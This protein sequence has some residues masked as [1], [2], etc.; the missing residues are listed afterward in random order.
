M[1]PILLLIEI[2]IV[3]ALGANVVGRLGRLSVLLLYPAIVMV[4]YV[5]NCIVLD[6]GIYVYEL[7]KLTYNTYSAQKYL[8]FL[9]IFLCCLI[10]FT[11]RK[12]LPP[13]YALTALDRCSLRK[14]WSWLFYASF[15]LTV[16]LSSYVLLDMAVSGIP[17]LSNGIITHYNYFKDYSSLP[18]AGAASNYLTF[19]AAL[20][21]ANYSLCETKRQKGRTVFLLGLALSVR[22]LLGFKATGLIDVAIAYLIGALLFGYRVDASKQKRLLK[23]VLIALFALTAIIFLFLNYQ[24]MSGEARSISE[25]WE[26]LGERFFEMGA[27]MWWSETADAS[28]FGQLLPLDLSEMTS[29]FSFGDEFDP[30]VGVYGMMQRYGDSYIVD[31]DMHNQVRFTAD[32]ITTA[33]YYDGL[34]LGL[35]QIAICAG[36]VSLFMRLFATVV[37]ERNPLNFVIAYRIFIPFTTYLCATGTLTTFF[38]LETYFVILI[39]LYI[40]LIEAWVKRSKSARSVRTSGS[41]C[42][43]ECGYCKRIPR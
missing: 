19:C 7:G 35:V 11:P 1:Y 14:E 42:R 39:L 21:G 4:Q 17:L 8:L 2:V 16:I 41:G 43:R 18:L 22:I 15:I 38:N 27:H 23:V 37:R 34:I 13:S 26:M 28:V 5:A 12:A 9:A 31:V 20:L 10:L 3:V 29:V 6:S 25:A 33:I 24:V 30:G 36:I 32:F 40:K